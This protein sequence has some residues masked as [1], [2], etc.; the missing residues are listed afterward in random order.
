MRVHFLGGFF[1][2]LRRAMPRPTDRSAVVELLLLAS[3]IFRS[4]KRLRTAAL[5]LHRGD[6]CLR[7]KIGAGPPAVADRGWMFADEGVM[8]RVGFDDRECLGCTGRSAA[9]EW[10]SAQGQSGRL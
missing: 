7:A 5:P 2:L 8:W 4:S 1:D 3:P 6:E 9:D 10:L